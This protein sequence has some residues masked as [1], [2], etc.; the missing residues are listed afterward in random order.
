MALTL[1]GTATWT[2]VLIIAV[3]GTAINYLLGDLVILPSSNNTTASI[4][5]GVVAAVLAYAVMEGMGTVITRDW[6]AI[7]IFGVLVAG[8]EFYFHNYLKKSDEVAP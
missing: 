8:F 5:D 7:L 6:W 4:V 1:I 3:V 2:E